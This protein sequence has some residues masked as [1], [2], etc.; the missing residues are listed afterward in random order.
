MCLREQ[1]QSPLEHTSTH[2]GFLAALALPFAAVLFVSTRRCGS[3]FVVVLTIG[4]YHIA[5]F[6]AIARTKVLLVFYLFLATAPTLVVF[7]Q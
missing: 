5:A 7:A 4:V 1:S 2:L 6:V 3:D